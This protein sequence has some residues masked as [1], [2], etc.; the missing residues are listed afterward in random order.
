MNVEQMKQ[1]VMNIDSLDFY[2][3]YLLGN[4]VWYYKNFLGKSDFSRIYDEMKRYIANK[5]GIHIND[6]AIFG[7][8]KIGFSLNPKK[9]FRDFT[10]KSDIDIVLVSRNLFYQFWNAYLE[11]YSGQRYIK[12]YQRVTSSL[13]R[14]FICLDGFD[15]SNER[16]IEWNKRASGFQKDLQLFYDIKEHTI[17]YRIFDSW[18]AVQRYYTR[19]LDDLKRGYSPEGGTEENDTEN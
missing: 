7:S 19:N 1:D 17:N 11:M 15:D 5:L 2:Q 3:K 14:Q 8:A 10:E 9:G 4:E 18:D 13:F 6:I 16:F 12:K